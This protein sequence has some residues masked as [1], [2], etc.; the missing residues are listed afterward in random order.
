M[1]AVFIRSDFG[2]KKSL[3]K[4][5]NNSYSES[6]TPS[7]NT[8]E[9]EL[10]AKESFIEIEGNATRMWTYNDQYPGPEMRVKLGDTIKINFTNNIPQETTIHFHGIRV[11]NA[12]DGVPGVT[13]DPIKTGGSFVYEF[14]PKDAGTYWYHPHVRGSEQVERGLIGTIVVENPN[15]PTYDKDLVIV[16]DDILLNDEGQ[17][18]E[19]FNTGRDLMHDGR[20]GNLVLTSG[21]R[22]KILEV[23]PGERIR[24]RFVNAS[25]GRV[26]KLNFNEL[27]PSGIAV[28]GLLAFEIFNPNGFELSPGNRLDVDLQIPAVSTGK[29][30][31]I[32]DTFTRNRNTLITLNPTENLIEQKT[33]N[34]PTASTKPKWESATKTKPDAEYILDARRGGRMGIEWTINGKTFEDSEPITLRAG[35]FNKIRF[36]NK[37]ARLHPMHLHGVFFKVLERNEKQV[38]EPYFRDTVLLK[39]DEVVD[40]GT[41]P[42]DKGEWA[43]HCHVLEHAESGMMTTVVVE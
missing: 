24:L 11:P 38:N 8:I 7:G 36:I 1:L 9:Y 29:S 4:N 2:L 20:W 23:D 37:S 22:N 14:T 34:P 39:A 17:I 16:L 32:S 3:V 28:D 30:Y 12:M 19:Q 21:S 25:N 42:L 43:N 10:E 35:E 15:E 40:I 5:F 26:Y 13:Q 18:Y 6:I 27:N 41:L 31:K 33:F